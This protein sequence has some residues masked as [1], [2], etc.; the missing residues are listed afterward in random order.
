MPDS[1][2][3][4]MAPAIGNVR[5]CWKKIG[6]WGDG[7]C[8]ELEKFVHCRNCPVYSDAAAEVLNG[9]APDGYLAEWTAHFAREKT[10]VVRDNQSVLIFR[11]GA[12]WLALSTDAFQQVSELKTVHSLPHRRSNVVLGLVNIRGELVVCISL[13]R[14]LKIDEAPVRK[15]EPG[16]AV[17]PFLLVLRHEGSRLAAPV[18]EI[19]GIH[20]FSAGEM[21]DLPATVD[22]ALSTYARGILPW[23]ERSVGWLDHALLFYSLNKSLS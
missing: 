9:R 17:R 20:H 22:V 10:A 11:L 6:V 23:R 14:A 3:S 4:I 8:P 13:P 15:A 19:G 16:R 21:K 2:P 5:D 1:V 12:E 7:S 18:D